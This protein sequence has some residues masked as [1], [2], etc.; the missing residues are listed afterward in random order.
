MK[1]FHIVFKENPDDFY[2]KGKNYESS[3]IIDA[4][5]DF[6]EEYP[7]AIYLSSYSIEDISPLNR[8]QSNQDKSDKLFNAWQEADYPG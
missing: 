5:K 1:K 2:S 3:N 4:I 8:L 7:V 6:Q